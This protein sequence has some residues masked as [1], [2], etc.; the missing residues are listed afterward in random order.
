MVGK[1]TLEYLRAQER[2]IARPVL[3][4][5]ATESEGHLRMI[6]AIE[7]VAFERSRDLHLEEFFRPGIVRIDERLYG[8]IKSG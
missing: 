3:T 5:G 1:K 8:F 7:Q 4:S 6:V 2:A